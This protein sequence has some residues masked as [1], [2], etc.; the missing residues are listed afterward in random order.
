[1]R[2]RTSFIATMVRI[3][4]LTACVTSCG[5]QN[6]TAQQ[7][8]PAARPPAANG[9]PVARPVDPRVQIREYLF[10][11]TKEQMPYALF[12]SSKVKPDKKSPLIVTLHG[13]GGT[14]TTMMRANALD[15][16]EA[17]GYILVS[18]MGYNPRGWYGSPPFGPPPGARAPNGSP[19]PGARPPGTRPE[20]ATRPP[21]G[22]LGPDPNDPPNLRELSEKDVM[23]VL[24]MMQKEFNV[25]PDRIYLM[26]HSMGGAGA[27][28]LAVKYPDKWAAVAAIAP[29]AFGLDPASL[30]KIPS[31]P[32]AFVHGDADDVVPVSISRTWVD[33]L[34]TN[35]M[36]YEYKEVAG[37][38]HG[39]VITL[40]QPDIF[41]FFD[42]HS[43]NGAD[44]RRD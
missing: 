7:P 26:G 13:L 11:D 35:K 36:T 43:K 39:N 38:D 12:V 20:G 5:S 37:G 14:H 17:R 16:A 2:Q 31:M 41:A 24:A 25:D 8:P 40:G 15:L 10:E 30:T 33:V 6:A 9:P 42:R 23:N 32:V 44:T 18:P 19:P 3:A 29:A 27:L 22:A 34:R 28:H 21:P 1:M 4:L